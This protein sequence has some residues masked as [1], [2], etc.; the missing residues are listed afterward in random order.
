MQIKARA[1]E[2][3]I[4]L[5][6]FFI[7]FILWNRL[8]RT[9][10]PIDLFT[11]YTITRLVVYFCLFIGSILIVFFF[12]R[13]ILN[14]N[15]KMLLLKRLLEK[16]LLISFISFVQE[17]I[18]NAPKNLY[19]WLYERIHIRDRMTPIGQFIYYHNLNERPYKMK[20]I[21]GFFYSFQILLCLTFIHNIFVLHKLTYFYKALI[22][23]IIP[24]LFRLLIFMQYNLST[25][26]KQNIETFID[27]VPKESNDGWVISRTEAYKDNPNLTDAK[28]DFYASY[29]YMYI[30]S[31]MSIDHFHRLE[32]KIK[33]YINIFCYSLYALGWGYILYRIYLNEYS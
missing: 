27:F 19:E 1:K 26:L 15:S 10:Q 2:L 18:L 11:E 9:R 7:V 4:I 12:I 33:P 5:G 22:L 14:I 32:A 6:L 3:S 24:M 28:M 25:K 21:L 16:P 23:L 8:I 13:K 20:L 17:Y 29:W 31:L 30:H